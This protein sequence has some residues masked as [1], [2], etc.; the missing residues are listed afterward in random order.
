M[1]AAP[2]TVLG[3][4]P[5]FTLKSR[6]SLPCNP[7]SSS[8]LVVRIKSCSPLFRSPGSLPGLFPFS[9]LIRHGQCRSPLTRFP[10]KPDYDFSEGEGRGYVEEG[11]WP[12][13]IFLINHH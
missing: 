7:R 6:R 8:L 5:P 4:Q 11:A 13:W 10:H 3:T 12:T 2:S 9:V 1:S